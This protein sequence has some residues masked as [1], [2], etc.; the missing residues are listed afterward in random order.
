M[1]KHLVLSGGG[2]TLFHYAGIFQSLI[3][4]NHVN[5]DEIVSVYGTSS[6]SI[7]GAML[8]LKYDW[9]DIQD[10][11]IRCPWEKKLK[12]G[13]QKA[14]QVFENNG[15]YDE[16]LFLHLFK[17]LL[18][19]KELNVD[20]TMNEFFQYSNIEF[21][22]YTF[23]LNEFIELD[24]SYLTHPDMKLLDAIRMSCSIPML[25]KPICLDG[26]CY[27]DGGVKNNYPLQACMGRED[28]NEENVL[29]FRNCMKE[30]KPLHE[31]SNITDYLNVILRKCFKLLS[32]KSPIVLKHELHLE[33]EGVSFEILM[34]ALCDIKIRENL[35]F[36]GKLMGEKY[37]ESLKECAQNSE[38]DIEVASNEDK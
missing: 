18:S 8:C 20:V 32:N 26:K 19:G 15:L 4:Q 17:S 28:S 36:R 5:M 37:L 31:N 22:V 21:H 9:N 34:D 7:I 27:I 10:F 25:I 14:L 29:G 24:I 6:G 35:V 30:L 1:I 3:N 13:F 16:N 38:N 11:I 12:V 33:T 23:E 2:H